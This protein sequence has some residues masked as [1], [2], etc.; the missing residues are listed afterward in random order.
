MRL[1]LP[2]LGAAVLAFAGCQST[3]SNNAAADSHTLDVNNGGQDR[4]SVTVPSDRTDN[5]QPYAVRGDSNNASN[6]AASSGTNDQ[7][8]RGTNGNY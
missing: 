1:L 4:Y 3:A 6:T 8:R 7:A 5:S 2:L